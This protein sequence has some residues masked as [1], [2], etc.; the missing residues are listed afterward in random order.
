MGVHIKPHEKVRA[1]M[2]L[3]GYTQ[4][5]LAKTIGIG[6]ATFNLK[7]NGKRDFTLPECQR[8]AKALGVTLDDIFF[9]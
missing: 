5:S 3:A 8:I 1:A 2:H 7:I 4:D 9:N 6:T